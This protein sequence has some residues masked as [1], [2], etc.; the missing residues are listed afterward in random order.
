[1][2]PLD[3][4]LL[5]TGVPEP[6]LWYLCR[7]LWGLWLPS[8]AL[9][10][11]TGRVPVLAGCWGM[12]RALCTGLGSSDF[13]FEAT[14]MAGIFPCRRFSKDVSKTTH[15]HTHRGTNL[16]T[17]PHTHTHTHTCT[18]KH[19][20][21]QKVAKSQWANHTPA[22]SMTSLETQANQTPVSSMTSYVCVCH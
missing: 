2:L 18:H 19:T 8:T 13:I 14:R 20:H 1:M 17:N 3:A 16:L 5:F 4:G 7:V 9:S 11:L 6:R 12:G 21:N 15:T 10:L 22:S